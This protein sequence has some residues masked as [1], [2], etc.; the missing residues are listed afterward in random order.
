MQIAEQSNPETHLLRLRH[1]SPIKYLKNSSFDHDSHIYSS[2]K[3]CN[4]V[5]DYNSGYLVKRIPSR[6]K[7]RIVPSALQDYNQ[8]RRNQSI[9]VSTTK[10]KL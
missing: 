7:Q 9:W 6:T 8:K 5:E 4:F 1:L 2:Q 3:I 10:R